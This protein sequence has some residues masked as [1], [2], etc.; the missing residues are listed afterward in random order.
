MRTVCAE[1]YSSILHLTCM[2]AEE[3]L[4]FVRGSS[5][6]SVKIG[7]V[8]S[9]LLLVSAAC[10]SYAQSTSTPMKPCPK[11]AV[12]ADVSF[13]RQAEE[14]GSI[15]RDGGAAEPGLQILQHHG[16]TWLRLRLFNH[17]ATLPNNLEYTLA[18][19]KAAKQMGFR[20]LLDLHYSDDWADPGHQI[21]P[22]AWKNLKHRELVDAV[23]TYTRDTIAAFRKGGALPDIVQVGNEVTAGI[24]WPDG[25]LPDNWSNFIDLLKA[26]VRGVNDGAGDG[27]KPKIMIHID[28]GGDIAATQWFFS[29][30][31]EENVPFDVI[32][33]SYYPWWQGSLSDLKDNL[34]FMAHTYRKPI[35]IVE[36][37]YSWKPDN[38]TKKKGPFPETPE[39]QRDFLRAV[40]DAVA[41]TPDGLGRGVFWWEPAVRGPLERRGLFDDQGEALPA[42]DVF[43]GCAR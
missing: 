5:G 35:V 24:L 31:I 17:P 38:Y 4:S 42:M 27:P 41:A 3:R 32:G 30:L 7:R 43:D 14:Q 15:F 8:C 39:G 19:A 13:L 23:Y 6:V 26:G 28:K 21:T 40:A 10:L 36:T 34:A 20:F 1:L 12:G 37:A 33:Q 16:Y 9:G 29:H 11:I 2:C 18:E 22:L 25:K